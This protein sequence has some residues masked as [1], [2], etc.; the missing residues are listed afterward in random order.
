MSRPRVIVAV[1]VAAFVLVTAVVYGSAMLRHRTPLARTVTPA[2]LQ[3]TSTIELAPG[4][5]AC[6]S[7]VP[8]TPEAQV[9]TILV[10]QAKPSP[11]LEVTADGRGYASGPVRI[12]GGIS[13]REPLR[14]RLKPPTS[15][16]LGRVCVR[17]VGEV[18]ANLVGTEEF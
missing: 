18:K 11:P 5:Q 1:V 10:D 14:A 15:E 9:A 8:L 3:V 17:N 2:P 12:D 7:P 16:L 4:A 6:S 13:G